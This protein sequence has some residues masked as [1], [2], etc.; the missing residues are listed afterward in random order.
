MAAAGTVKMLKE[1]RRKYIRRLANLQ[2]KVAK[3]TQ[4]SIYIARFSQKS[5]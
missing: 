4:L 3:L 2:N 1:T 5:Q